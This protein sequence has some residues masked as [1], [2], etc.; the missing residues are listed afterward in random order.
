MSDLMLNVCAWLRH[1]PPSPQQQGLDLGSW[2]EWIAAIAAFAA[3]VISVYALF[4]AWRASKR[5]SFIDLQQRL[6]E[7][8]V[9]EGRRIIY[10]TTS[11]ED[12]AK[13]FRK[14]HKDSRWDR[15][16]RAVNLWDTL[17]QF[18][19]L[20]IVDRRLSLELWG[21]SV[22]EAWAHLEFYIRFRRGAGYPEMLGR[23]D[24][25][26]SLVWFAAEVGATVSDDLLGEEHAPSS[27][28]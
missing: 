3:F 6:D 13:L 5:N 14:R 18:T 17:A 7:R 26:S 24:K 11:V 15:A 19:R 9:S 12:V 8:E 16:N 25:W 10:A 28:P 27:V 20:G 23:K 1:R 4:V 2:A 21:G 22:K